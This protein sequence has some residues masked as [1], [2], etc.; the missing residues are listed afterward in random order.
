MAEIEIQ[1]NGEK[2]LVPPGLTVA[3]L[4][5]HLSLD[6]ERVA[7]ELDRELVRRPQWETR[8]VGNGAQLEV[9][10]FVGGGYL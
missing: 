4:L 2:T 10:H 7:V 5:R 1:L 9:V 3:G 8:T 6:L